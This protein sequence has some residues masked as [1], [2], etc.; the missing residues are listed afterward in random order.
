MPTRDND[1][2]SSRKLFDKHH[3]DSVADIWSAKEH[4]EGM[5][6]LLCGDIYCWSCAVLYLRSPRLE[7][8]GG[9]EDSNCLTCIEFMCSIEWQFGTEKLPPMGDQ[10]QIVDNP[11]RYQPIILPAKFMIRQEALYKKRKRAIDSTIR[12][13]AYKKR[14]KLN[15]NFSKK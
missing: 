4:A 3:S 14:R 5:M 6:C 12:T 7:H 2:T 13:A 1:P 11:D 15:A 8:M 9:G 10:K